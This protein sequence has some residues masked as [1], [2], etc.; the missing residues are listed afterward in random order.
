MVELF[1]MERLT[2]LPDPVKVRFRLLPGWK[3]PTRAE[4][5]RA[6]APADS[7]SPLDGILWVADPRIRKLTAFAASLLRSSR[8]PQKHPL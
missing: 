4:V 6:L 8:P 2:P 7:P 3:L 5:E 1:A